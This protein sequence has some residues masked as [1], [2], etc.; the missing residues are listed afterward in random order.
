MGF[1]AF[2]LLGAGVLEGVLKGLSSAV[3]WLFADWR[4]APLVVFATG[5]AFLVFVKI[6]GLQADLSG[7]AAQ[8]EAEQRAH[9]GTVNAFLAASAQAQ[10][11][12]DANVARVTAQQE[13]VTN[14]VTRD[15]R[16]DLAAV[17]TRFD[18]LRAQGAPR[19]DPRRA[20][21][22]DLPVAGSSPT[23]AVGAAADQDVLAPG[24]LIACPLGFVCL[25]FDEAQ[26][27]SE[28]AHRHDRLIDWVLAQFAVPFTPE[29]RPE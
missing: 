12:A 17:V 9:L 22:I 10:R 11:E 5:F 24:S 14:E 3:K 21:P 2:K 8:L 18:R 27:A 1:A 20:D 16:S 29:D 6:P 13:A 23:S 25:T 28:D 15:L 7:T 19:T 26:R 4:H